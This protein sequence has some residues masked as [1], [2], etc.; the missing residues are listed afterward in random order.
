MSDYYLQD[1]SRLQSK[2]KATI[3]DYVE[4]NGILVP[5]RFTSLAQA[6]A[7]N[8]PFLAR[9]EHPQEYDGAS[10]LLESYSNKDL[11]NISSEQELIDKCEEITEEGKLSNIAQYCALTNISEQEFRNNISYSFWELLPGYNQ[12]I[13]ADS[14]IHGRYHIMTKDKSSLMNYTIVENEKITS[15]Q[16]YPLPQQLKDN[17]PS[18]IEMY[19]TIRHLSHFNPNHCPIMEMQTVGDQHYFLQYHRTRDFE[20][21]TFTLNCPA[22]ADESKALFVRGATPPQGLTVDVTLV[23]ATLERFPYEQS[24]KGFSKFKFPKNDQASFDKHYYKLFAELLLPQRKVQIN[25]T[26]LDGA[27]ADAV[28]GHDTRSKLFKPEISVVQWPPLYNSTERNELREKALQ[29][30]KDQKI[31]VHVISDGTTAYVQRV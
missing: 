19:E 2:P 11:Q 1:K 7:S 24:K 31:K 28:N 18:L 17:L 29:T 13:I 25:H 9:S 5:H 10:G 23:Y 26:S 3:A 30:G 20:P 14:A 15:N 27:F 4:Q 16:I 6:R 8:L 12:T 21:S 22:N